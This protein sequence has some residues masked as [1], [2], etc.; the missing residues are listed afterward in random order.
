M[1]CP[2]DKY[3]GAKHNSCELQII[4]NMMHEVITFLSGRAWPP[5]VRHQLRFPGPYRPGTGR[6]WQADPDPLR[7][8]LQPSRRGGRVGWTKCP[9][10]SAAKLSFCKKGS[11]KTVHVMNMGKGP[12][13]TALVNELQTPFRDMMLDVLEHY[14]PV[15]L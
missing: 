14:I 6:R 5:P 2:P 1:S 10:G 9:R 15:T 13:K 4:S 3:I 8:A 7:P 11:E 12:Q